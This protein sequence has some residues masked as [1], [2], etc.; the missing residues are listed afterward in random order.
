MNHF[1]VGSDLQGRSAG[2]RACCPRMSETPCPMSL[3]DDLMWCV[4]PHVVCHGS[5]T[6]ASRSESRARTCKEAEEFDRPGLFSNRRCIESDGSTPSSSLSNR[7]HRW[8][9]RQASDQLPSARCDLDEGM[10]GGFTQRFQA[11]RG[12]CGLDGVGVTASCTQLPG[13]GFPAR[14]AG[15]GEALPARPAASR[16][17]KSGNR[18]PARSLR[19]TRIQVYGLATRSPAR[20]RRRANTTRLRTST[21]MSAPSPRNDGV[22]AIT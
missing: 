5:L 10:M 12:E 14:A 17:T 15:S 8:N 21:S 7:R 6:A 9:W 2:C 3:A 11:N 13:R 1:C 22:A 20:L 16:H 19:G 18:S 4:M